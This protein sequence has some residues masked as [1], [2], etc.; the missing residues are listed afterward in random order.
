MK[1][2]DRR[3]LGTVGIA[4]MASAV[5]IA[6]AV[7]TFPSPRYLIILSIP[8]GMMLLSSGALA[9][10]RATEERSGPFRLTGI[11]LPGAAWGIA[12]VIACCAPWPIMIA[13]HPSVGPASLPMAVVAALCGTAGA[14]M[15]GRWAD[16]TLN[17]RR[18]ADT[19]EENPA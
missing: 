1:L 18:D 10:T 16:L 5:M 14:I 7:S 4:L 2:H 8:I 15:A 11:L 3:E 17:T 13:L 6:V 9:V 12:S 19:T